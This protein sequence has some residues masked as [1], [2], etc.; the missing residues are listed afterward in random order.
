MIVSEV[1][2]SSVFLRSYNYERPVIQNTLSAQC[3]F[4]LWER[5]VE[6]D[7]ASMKIAILKNINKVKCISEIN[8]IMFLCIL[9]INKSNRL[10]YITLSIYACETIFYVLEKIDLFSCKYFLFRK[11]NLLMLASI[12]HSSFFPSKHRYIYTHTKY[13]NQSIKNMEVWIVCVRTI[14]LF[15]T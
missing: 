5:V 2:S 4:A 8:I 12:F 15:Y 7:H 9:I 3:S 1:K 13:D 14:G 11:T 6:Q 10:I